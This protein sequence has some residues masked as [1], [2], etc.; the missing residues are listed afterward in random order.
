MIAR[1]Q[2]S[3]VAGVSAVYDLS[4]GLTLL[5]AADRFAALF[6]VTV[7]EPRVFVTVCGLL[8]VCVGLGY[9]SP[10]RDPARH[11]A[12]LWVFGPLLK[13]AG[14]MVFLWEYLWNGS[15]ASYLVFVASD[16]LLAL[17]TLFVLVKAPLKP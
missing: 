16:G 10:L 14:A 3:V 5:V 11:Q 12:Y 1:R 7:P 9:I 13:G 2:Q 8:L 15:P 6:N 17:A 4:I